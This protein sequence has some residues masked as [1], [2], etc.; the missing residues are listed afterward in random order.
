MMRL[1]IISAKNGIHRLPNQASSRTDLHIPTPN[2][3][4]R[5]EVDI[6]L[7]QPT[8]R[9]ANGLL[10]IISL[11]W[12]IWHD[13]PNV[14]SWSWFKRLESQSQLL[15]TQTGKKRGGHSE[16][17]QKPS[18][19]HGQRGSREALR[20]LLSWAWLLCQL[21]PFPPSISTDAFYL[22]CPESASIFCTQKTMGRIIPIRKWK[23]RVE[24]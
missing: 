18:K 17:L 14:F 21:S 7:K 23:A 13:Q 19:R 20:H 12:Q 16:N 24:M 5:P 15:G 9:P 22:G 6:L 1:F 8:Q 11:P 3:S 4:P 10:L 2:H